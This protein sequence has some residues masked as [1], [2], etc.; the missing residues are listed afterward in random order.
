MNKIIELLEETSEKFT[1]LNE[2]ALTQL[3]I[4]ENIDEYKKII[5]KKAHLLAELPKKLSKQLA[6][7]KDE[8]IKNKI[9]YKTNYLAKQAQKFIELSWNLSIPTPIEYWENERS[10]LENLIQE[11]K[12]KIQY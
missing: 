6:S 11:I 8:E 5:I 10:N 3:R 12:E 9:T 1:E 7:I 2:K 4:G